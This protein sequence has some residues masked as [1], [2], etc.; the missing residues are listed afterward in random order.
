[1]QDATCMTGSDCCS[2]MCIGGGMNMHCK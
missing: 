1:M 2:G